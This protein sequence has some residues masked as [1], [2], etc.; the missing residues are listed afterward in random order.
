MHAISSLVRCS[1]NSIFYEGTD[2]SAT[3]AHKLVKMGI[4][5]VPEGRGIFP[6]LTVLENINLGAYLRKDKAEIKKDREWI[7]SIF[8]RLQERSSQVGGTLSGGEQQMLAIARSL[9]GRPS[10]LLLD[11]PSMGLAPIIVEEIFRIIKKINREQNTTILLVEQ[12]AQ[13]ALTVSKRAYVIEIGTV[14][15]EGYSKEMRNDDKI[16]KAYLGI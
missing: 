10:L 3:E 12:N 13:M 8:P 15:C 1:P 6:N 9:M 16:Q 7:F 14:I 2:I 11:E 4:L 5:Q